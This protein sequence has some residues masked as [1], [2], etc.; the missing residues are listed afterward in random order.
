[1]TGSSNGIIPADGQ[2]NFVLVAGHM[3]LVEQ[4]GVTALLLSEPERAILRKALN[5]TES[6]SRGRLPLGI[7]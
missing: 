6:E 2:G 5:L 1:M 4:D 3:K 7:G